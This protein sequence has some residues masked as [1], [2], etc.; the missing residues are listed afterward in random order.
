MRASDYR[1]F[2][3]LMWFGSFVMLGV[4]VTGVWTGQW[5]VA[6]SGLFSLTMLFGASRAIY[7][8]LRWLKQRGVSMDFFYEI[9]QLRRRAGRVDEIRFPRSAL[10]TERIS[11]SDS[12]N[13]VYRM[14]QTRTGEFQ[15]ADVRTVFEES[16]SWVDDGGF[17]LADVAKLGV[18]YFD[19]VVSTGQKFVM[20]AEAGADIHAYAELLGSGVEASD[21]SEY[22]SVLGA[23]AALPFLRDGIPLEFAR[24]VVGD[25]RD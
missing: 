2:Q 21:I 11:R 18:S 4:L 19:A 6:F 15:P 20:F 9:Q 22:M 12:Y 8:P 16:L 3:Q 13:R 1:M 23:S 25:D 14:S 10:V 5:M 24:V 17:D 7:R